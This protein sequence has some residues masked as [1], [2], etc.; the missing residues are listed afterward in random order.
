MQTALK[1][2]YA[3]LRNYT[4]GA[5]DEA[6]SGGFFWSGS[7]YLTDTHLLYLNVTTVSPRSTSKRADGFS[8]RCLKN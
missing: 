3:G 5:W 7:P 6:G 4:S 8:V 2:P 1:L